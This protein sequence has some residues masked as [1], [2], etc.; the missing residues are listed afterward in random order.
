[1]ADTNHAHSNPAGVGPV[2][3]DDIN[4]RGILWFVV[5]LAITMG[6]S[7]LLMVGTFKLFD[8]QI[9]T[10]DKERPALATPAGQAPPSPNLLYVQSGAPVVSEPGNLE[11]FREREDAALE[12]YS[13]D[14]A[15][16]VATIPIERA[17]EL[18]LARGLPTRDRATPPAAAPGKR[19]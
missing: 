6:V 11:R 13:L 14:K 7:N 3:N 15:T 2:E 4:Y 1:M 5:V 19:P 8:H 12:G 18:L 9:V 10:A 17:K 16:G